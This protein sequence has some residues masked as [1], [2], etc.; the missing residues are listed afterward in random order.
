MGVI[1]M[2]T[3]VEPFAS[4][5][6]AANRY[7]KAPSL[8]NVFESA[9]IQLDLGGKSACGVSANEQNG[10]KNSLMFFMESAL[11]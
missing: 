1:I 4:E 3:G 10:M 5:M 7:P 9:L 8:L 11:A 2:P 6:R